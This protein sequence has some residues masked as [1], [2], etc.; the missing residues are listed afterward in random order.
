MLFRSK[1]IVRFATIF[2]IVAF[3]FGQEKDLLSLQKCIQ[4]KQVDSAEVYLK[5]INNKK[6]S[7]YQKAQLD[8]SKAV[9]FRIKNQDNL[10]F[11]SYLQAKKGF[12]TLDSVSKVAQIN[13]EL[14]SMLLAIDKSNI[15]YNLYLREFIDYAKKTNNPKF[16]S[17]SYMQLGKAF[18]DENPQLSIKYFKKAYQENQKTNDE[19]YG[20]RILQNIGA[21]YASDNILNLDSALIV[22]E[23]A[24][25]I[26]KKN[27]E[28]ELESYIYINKGVVFTKQKKYEAAIQSFLKAD[29]IPVKEFKNKNKE[30][31]YGFLAAAYKEKGDFKSALEYLEK[32]KVF[33]EILDESD[34]KK[35]I[36]EIDVKYKTKEKELENISLKEKLFKNKLAFQFALFTLILV[37]IVAFLSVKNISKKKKIIEQDRK[38]ALSEFEKKLKENELREIDKM[39]EGQEKER[40]RIADELHDHLGSLLATLKMNFQVL[41]DRNPQEPI[42]EKT[43]KLLDE[44]YNEVR[45]ISHL[46]NMGMIG[47]E[48]LLVAVQ[49]MAEKMSAVNKIKFHVI[50]F[51]LEGRLE[52]TVELLLFRSIQ[53]LCSN[54]LKHAQASEVN[55]YLTQHESSEINVM[56]EDNGIG[57]DPQILKK[58][59]GIGL[60]NLER[61]IEQL[62]GTLSVDSQVSGGTT[63]IIDLPL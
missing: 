52:S 59:K 13:V 23:K 63:I 20:A 9:L 11:E 30:A 2:F 3:S 38:I 50:P 10:S 33:Q 46:K 37:I 24:L 47:K 6:L 57:F 35:A 48:G 29:S 1:I 26:Y 40:Q 15:D 7:V 25:Q 12:N 62:H 19:V 49:E 8:Y 61:K 22:Y 17:Q 43:E 5:R 53:E 14:V 32:Q 21:T 31:L 18:Y 28:T 58:N 36:K 39:L 56:I 16:I 60:K 45:N 54:I 41:K 44:T 4:S 55:I 27:K 51:G 42:M 34:Q